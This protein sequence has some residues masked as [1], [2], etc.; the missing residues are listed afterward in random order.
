MDMRKIVV[1]NLVISMGLL[2]LSSPLRATTSLGSLTITKIACRIFTPNGDGAN[3][4]ARFELDNPEQLPVAG[5]VYDL[6]GAR[7]ASLQ[8]GTGSSAVDVLLWDGKNGDGQVVAGGI[9]I[10]DIDF[11]GKHATGTV[12]VAR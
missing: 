10:Y 11:Q 5:T 12:V 2:A 1:I 3:D 4:K 7:V 6:S 9:Y 8:Q